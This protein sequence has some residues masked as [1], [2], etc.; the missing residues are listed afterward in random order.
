MIRRHAIAVFALVV[1]G[2]GGCQREPVQAPAR[3]TAA[4]APAAP[5]AQAAPAGDPWA[6]APGKPQ[7]APKDRLPHPFLWAVEKDGHTTYLFGTIHLGVDAEAKLP[8]AVWQKLD[9]AKAFA[10]ETDINDPGLVK[11]LT[12]RPHG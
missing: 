4:S 2:A 7:D 8:D 10:M 6:A 12:A 1:A 3:T 5:P 9:A 11:E